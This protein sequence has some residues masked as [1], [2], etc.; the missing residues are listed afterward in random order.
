M[1][2]EKLQKIGK[3]L[4]ELRLQMGLTFEQAAEKAH[5]AKST[6]QRIEYGDEGLTLSTLIN[7]M[8]GICDPSASDRLI[9]AISSVVS[10]ETSKIK[11][12]AEQRETALIL[13]RLAK[14]EEIN[15]D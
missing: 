6:I 5:L 2:N 13:M 12:K 7:Y 9:D 4:R 11:T 8:K 1:P 3:S 14:G 15:E 10:K